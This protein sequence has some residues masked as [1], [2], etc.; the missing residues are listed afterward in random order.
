MYSKPKILDNLLSTI[1]SFF[2]PKPL[3][4]TIPSCYEFDTIKIPDYVID[5]LRNQVYKLIKD[6][7]VKK[8]KNGYI[9]NINFEQKQYVPVWAH[10][11][12][13]IINQTKILKSGISQNY[14]I[15]S[16]RSLMTIFSDG[17]LYVYPDEIKIYNRDYKIKQILNVE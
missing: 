8:I 2:K 4:I 16:D 11:S 6:K 9:I 14:P 17:C 7:K 10:S 5:D 12:L 15:T 13:Q 3:D 1:V